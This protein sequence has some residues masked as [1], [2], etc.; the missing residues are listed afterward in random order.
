MILDFD[1]VR[2]ELR[3]G[4]VDRNGRAMLRAGA[5]ASEQTRLEEI[6]YLLGR[7]LETEVNVEQGYSRTPGRCSQFWA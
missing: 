7:F 4:V 5:S 6:K 1:D 2:L 3:P